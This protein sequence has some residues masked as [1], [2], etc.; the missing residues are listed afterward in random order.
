MK[1]SQ[2][3]AALILALLFVT[4]TTPKK[5]FDKGD[6]KGAYNSALKNLKNDKKAT[7]LNRDILIKSLDKIY[8]TTRK[9]IAFYEHSED[10]REVEKALDI[11]TELLIKIKKALPYLDGKFD[12]NYQKTLEKD[13]ELADILI[14]E[15]MVIG[16]ENLSASMDVGD[17]FLAQKAFR[18]FKKAEKFGALDWNLDSLYQLCYDHGTLV[19]RVSANAPFEILFNW[20]IDR[21][22]DNVTSAGNNFKRV[23]YESSANDIDCD[24][25]VQF[26]SLQYRTLDNVNT[27]TFRESIVDGYETV[28]DTSGNIIRQEIRVDIEGTVNIIETTK[29]AEW[30]AD[31]SV[32]GYSDNCRLS[33]TTLFGNAESKATRHELSGDERA[34]PQRYKSNFPDELENDKDMAEAILEGIYRQ[35]VDRYF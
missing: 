10:L 20:K 22:F 2:I 25:D 5:K 24:I 8:L 14:H 9:D 1:P 23:V 27:Q 17:K 13:R 26:G 34:I 33:G 31:I 3:L 30:K 19:Y 32:S 29:I 6:F 15:Y 7:D 12:F 35:F 11:N 18:N 16:Q 28:T 4:C 21:T